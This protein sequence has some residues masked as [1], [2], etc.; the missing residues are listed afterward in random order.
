MKTLIVS[1]NSTGVTMISKFFDIFPTPIT[2]LSAA[3][4]D[5]YPQH[6]SVVV[7]P[8][9]G[10]TADEWVSRIRGDSR[11]APL[12]DHYRECGKV[13]LAYSDTGRP[14]FTNLDV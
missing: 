7:T 4:L 6:L 11:Y 5:A 2:S 1:V 12:L 8:K 9:V 3:A 10:E 14:P 13:H